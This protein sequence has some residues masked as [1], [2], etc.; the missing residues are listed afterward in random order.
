MQLSRA[1][2]Q[3]TKEPMLQPAATAENGAP[4]QENGTE[5]VAS[6]ADLFGSYF[7]QE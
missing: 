6:P 7:G 1:G 2:S 4:I 3:E 5:Q